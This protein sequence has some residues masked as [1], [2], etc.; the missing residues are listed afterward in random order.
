MVPLPPTVR[1]AREPEALLLLRARDGDTGAFAQLAGVLARTAL[2][3]AQRILGDHAAAEDVVQEALV[4]LWREAHR[5][6]PGRGMFAAWWR[7]MLVNCALDSRR[8]LRLAGPIDA[9]SHLADPGPGPEEAAGRSEIARRVQ[10][11]A[12]GLPARQRAALALFYGDG[13]SM[14]EIGTTIGCS[15]KAVEGLLLRGR[16]ALKGRLEAVYGRD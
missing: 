7:R 5:F 4:R 11:A 13:L 6:D 12:E 8:R 14:A 2:A 9:A 10:R 3:Q 15:E 1:I 16:A